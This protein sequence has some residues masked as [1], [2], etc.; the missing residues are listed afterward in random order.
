ML[1]VKEFRNLYK[2]LSLAR[3]KNMIYVGAGYKLIK[4]NMYNVWG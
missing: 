3:T 1:M 2:D 4:F